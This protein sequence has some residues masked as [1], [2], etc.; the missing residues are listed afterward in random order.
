MIE[1]SFVIPAYNVEKYIERC[2]NSIYSQD[3]DESLYEVIVVDDGSTDNTV[4]VLYQYQT[5]HKNFQVTSQTNQGVSAARNLGL[6]L[7]KGE[8]LWFVDSDDYIVDGA[9]SFLLGVVEKDETDILFFNCLVEKTD[10]SRYKALLQPVKKNVILSGEA[11]LNQGFY[12]SSVWNALWKRS[13]LTKL[14]L[15]FKLGISYGEDSLFVFSA[16]LQSTSVKFLNEELYVYCIREGSA[17]TTK[18]NKEKLLLAKYSDIAV[19]KSIRDLYMKYEHINPTL[20]E[21]AQKQ[22]QSILFGLVY[23]V[24]K[25]RK[26]WKHNG[27]SRTIIDRLKKEELYPLKGPFHS[28]KRWIMSRVLNYESLMT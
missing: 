5:E 21:L 14:G 3:I 16:I 10:G 19:I 2:L 27:M 6:T 25:N 18:H 26:T 23:S 1:L 12:P 20:S 22:Y 13:Y 28:F 7:A 11:A 15:T 24:F 4:D 9:I 8:Y 17:T